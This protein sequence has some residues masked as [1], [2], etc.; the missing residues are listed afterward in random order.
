M[1]VERKE[2]F[3]ACKILE[4]NGDVTAL[5]KALD[6]DDSGT[7]TLDELA[8]HV[9]RPLALFKRW[10]DTGFGNTKALFK[11]LNAVDH[12]KV[13]VGHFDLDDWVDA[14]TQLGCPCDAEEIFRLLDWER[15]DQISVHDARCLDKWTPEEYLMSDPSPQAAEELKKQFLKKYKHWLSAW[16]RCIDIDGCGR[17]SWTEFK[18]AA[19]KAMFT[20]DVAGAWLHLDNDCSGYVTLAELDQD[21]ADCLN[22]FRRWAQ[23]EYGSVLLG[24]E[25]IIGEGVDSMNRK[26]FR[27]QIRHHGFKGNADALFMSLDTDGSGGLGRSEV[28]FL[29]D[30]EL[31]DL[32]EHFAE[33]SLLE[34][35]DVGRPHKR[36][37]QTSDVSLIA[38]LRSE[39]FTPVVGNRLL[40]I[41]GL[42]VDGSTMNRPVTSP[43]VSV[44]KNEPDFF[45]LIGTSKSP[46]L[47][48]LVISSNDPMQSIRWRRPRKLP[49]PS[50]YAGGL[51]YAK[52]STT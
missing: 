34:H 44:Q 50:F 48:G 51:P 49:K 40:E 47:Q 52:K 2:L 5:W 9:A 23:H 41:V 3:Q 14:C 22:E 17:C 29:D 4:W 35:T 21:T 26:E 13:R 6:A 43:V 27:K 37:R 28:A 33:S 16:R 20:G 1:F 10:A 42:Q 38:K 39:R 24:F 7:T 36:E 8:I 31:A 25:S 19:A 15:R 45:Q 30:W 46:P 18:Q 11:A 12:T 32:E